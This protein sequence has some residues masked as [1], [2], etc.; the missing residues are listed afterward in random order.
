MA[1]DQAQRSPPAA[2]EAPRL[3]PRDMAAW[4]RLLRRYLDGAT[5]KVVVHAPGKRRGP[6]P[7][8]G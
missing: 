4:M 1:E 6:R 5:R 7:R 3:T 2:P 8:Q